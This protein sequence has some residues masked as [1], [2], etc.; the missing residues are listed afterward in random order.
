MH[1]LPVTSS[2]PPSTSKTLRH[3]PPL[4]AC[5]SLPVR[6]ALLP[7][8]HHTLTVRPYTIMLGSSVVG[9]Y[10]TTQAAAWPAQRPP[11][12]LVARAGSHQPRK[13][14]C[15]SPL[16]SCEHPRSVDPAALRSGPR[17]DT[18]S[19]Q[20]ALP[21]HGSWGLLA[22]EAAAGQLLPSEQGAARQPTWPPLS[23]RATRTTRRWSLCW[24]H[25]LAWSAWRRW[26]R[27]Q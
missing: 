16:Y 27:R 23:P 7:G 5:T 17:A 24:S 15:C 19:A 2:P 14:L 12:R 18:V 3:K 4:H 21:V 9:D 6:Q 25:C 22:A 20:Q 8:A 13:G 1:H 11:Q 26:R 10:P